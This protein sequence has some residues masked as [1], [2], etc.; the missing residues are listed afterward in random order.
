MRVAI[1]L[2]RVG[3]KKQPSF[4]IVAVP[5]RSPRDGK[6]LEILGSHGASFPGQPLEINLERYDHWI[7]V[8]AKPSKRVKKIVSKYRKAGGTGVLTQD[9]SVVEATPKEEVVPVIEEVVEE[10]AGEETPE[11]PLSEEAKEEGDAADEER[12]EAVVAEALEES[13][14]EEVV[15]KTEEADQVESLVDTEESPSEEEG[16]SEEPE[17]ESEEKTE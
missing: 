13:P 12:T 4:R 6:S 14:V 8:G 11:E 3:K 10:T 15:E 7:S 5:Y 2:S 1:R 9:G 16:D 17:T